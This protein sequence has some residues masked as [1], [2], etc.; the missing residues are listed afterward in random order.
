M[1]FDKCADVQMGKCANEIQARNV[2][3]FFA[4]FA[5]LRDQAVLKINSN[6]QIVQ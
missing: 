2:R 5:P 3:L 1:T 6:F 4:D